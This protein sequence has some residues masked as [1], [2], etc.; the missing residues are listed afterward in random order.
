[1]GEDFRMAQTVTY[2]IFG[3]RYTKG[4]WF[5]NP[6][7]VAILGTKFL[8]NCVY[9]SKITHN[10]E[11]SV[12]NTHTKSV[13]AWKFFKK[14]FLAHFSTFLHAQ[15]FLTGANPIKLFTL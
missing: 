6:F 14:F 13:F 5:A 12:K 4:N 9:S 1:M 10:S 2:N 15:L 8:T 11:L 3:N 7:V